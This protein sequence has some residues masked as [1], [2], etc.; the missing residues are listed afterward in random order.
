MIITSSTV[1]M[2]S[3][4]SYQCYEQKESVTILEKAGEAVTLDISEDAKSLSEQ[5]KEHEI[6]KRESEKKQQQENMKKLLERMN[7][8]KSNKTAEEE[9][10]KSKEEVNL[11]ILKKL[12]AELNRMRKGKWVNISDEL[13]KLKN[14]YKSLAEYDEDKNGWID[15]ADSI[16]QE[17]KVWTKDE[18]GEDKLI[19][20]KKADV[21]A[22]YLG[23]ADTEFSLN[24]MDT[25]HTN[26][27][28][29]KT[30]IYLKESG[31]AGTV[32]HVDLAV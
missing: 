10:P 12:I 15:E 18:N 14:S 32:Q 25:N 8:A 31:G 22:I 27:V 9:G 7:E 4:R 11:E 17:L 5:M 6:E 23:S 26:G 13:T 3:Q 19:D 1:G 2:S 28:I 16:Y 30:G 20:L 21:G 24:D 29:R